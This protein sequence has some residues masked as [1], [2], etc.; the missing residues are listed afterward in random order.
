[1]IELGMAA[2]PRNSGPSPRA[3]GRRI[4]IVV[5]AVVAVGL[6]AAGL[7]ALL[8]GGSAP[9][10]HP[11]GTAAV[12]PAG[13]AGV[14]TE[15]PVGVAVIVDDRLVLPDGTSIA[16]PGAGVLRR[17]YET[18]D[19]WLVEEPGGLWLVKHDHIVHRLSAAADVAVAPDG[20]RFAWRTA[21]TMSV[22]HLAGDTL[23]T[24][25]TVPA[26]ADGTP[27]RYTGSAVILGGGC[28][29]GI[30]KFDVWIPAKGPYVPSWS[31]TA[32]VRGVDAVLPGTGYLIGQVAGRAG[33]KDTCLA[34]LDPTRNLRAVWTACGIVRF[35]DND[36]SVSLDGHWAAI[37]TFD[38]TTGA[39]AVGL[40]D[41][42][43]AA[44]LKVA[45]YLTADPPCVWLD[46]T[47]TLCR[48]PDLRLRE[49]R[50]GS[51]DW[52]PVS[53][54]GVTDYV[55]TTVLPLQRLP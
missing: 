29:S 22:G 16:I 8:P 37:R 7:V 35:V 31:A 6:G 4:A 10:P 21:T 47:S 41:L 30:T 33:L 18:R 54:P 43:H 55:K 12:G 2:P 53:V 45:Q 9:S 25:Q 40:V 34:E 1:M 32:H 28:C 14:S 38:P 3:G 15:V 13:T 26:P 44:A 52:E 17:G 42:T 46:G 24:D 48:G 19:G 27:F 11:S 50:V 51:H 5:A 23:V 39:N 36:A 20:R 49:F